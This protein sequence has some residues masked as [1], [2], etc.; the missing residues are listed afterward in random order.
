MSVRYMTLLLWLGLLWPAVTAI[1]ADLDGWRL[2]ELSPSDQLAVFKSPDGQLQLLRPGGRL[3]E[4]IVLTGFDSDRVVL[5]S[6]ESG[7]G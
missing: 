5:E 4:R 6:R 2:M 7:E 1:A 3:G